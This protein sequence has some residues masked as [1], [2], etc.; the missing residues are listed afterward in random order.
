MIEHSQIN[1]ESVDDWLNYLDSLNPEKIELGLDRI[2]RVFL[3]M[4][5]DVR[6][7]IITVAGTNGK[8]TTVAVLDALLSQKEFSCGA[9]TS[10]HLFHFSERIRICGA[11]VSDK[12]LVDGFQHVERCRGDTVLTYFEFSTLVAAYIFSQ[13]DLD[14]WLLEVGL[15][16]RLDA[17][18]IFEPDA[19][20]VTNIGTDHASWLG[21]TR[22]KIGVEKAGIYRSH[23]PAIYSAADR[24]VTID[25]AIGE[26]E[27]SP[28][29]YR[30]HFEVS[31]N[32]FIWQG[33]PEAAIPRLKNISEEIVAGAIAGLRSLG[34][35]VI[36]KELEVLE[37][38][39]IPGR[40]QTLTSNRFGRTSTFIADV[41][42]NAE[43]VGLLA[44][45]LT[46]NGY[47]DLTAVFGCMTD[48][49][50]EDLL[51]P[52]IP[53]VTRWIL[54][55]PNVPRALEPEIIQSKLIALGVEKSQITQ[56]PKLKML[57]EYI[58]SDDNILVYGSFY[59]V[60][61]CLSE[62]GVKID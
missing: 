50:L 20:I 12:A 46:N 3:A 24:P 7:R 54:C 5:L 15:G 59:T 49:N 28:V 39:K 33:R 47:I 10:P 60:G 41:A 37:D 61:E 34:M 40:F 32:R 19:A 13:S 11:R 57:S 58:S 31:E 17:V 23:K 8:G 30:K 27:A 38:L 52:L 35:S 22:E 48:K 1:S 29:L 6:S 44:N 26:R 2:R 62:L 53:L 56:C 4:K 55:R 45:R 25:A 21:D 9:Y 36:D 42:H 18:N 14:F 51:K 16:G 43:S